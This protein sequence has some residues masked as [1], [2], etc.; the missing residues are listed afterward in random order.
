MSSNF[1]ELNAAMAL[2]EAD[3][4]KN[5]NLTLIE[6]WMDVAGASLRE[7]AKNG[8]D[9]D[10]NRTGELLLAAGNWLSVERK[11]IADAERVRLHRIQGAASDADFKS[12]FAR[13][14]SQAPINTE[15]K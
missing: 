15:R 14:Y 9:R 5:K 2:A 1:P 7:S 8:R 4:L 12:R 11:N 6:L 3:R 10:L 13:G